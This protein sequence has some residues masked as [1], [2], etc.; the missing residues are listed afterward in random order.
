MCAFIFLLFYNLSDDSLLTPEDLSYEN[1]KDYY[2]TASDVYSD[3]CW[4]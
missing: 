1:K 2:V 3:S 4:L